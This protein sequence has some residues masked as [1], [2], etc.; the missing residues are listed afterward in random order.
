MKLCQITATFDPNLW[1]SL[2]K[3][4]NTHGQEYRILA[5]DIGMRLTSGELSWSLVYNGEQRRKASIVSFRTV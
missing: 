2:P 3:K 1:E 5:Y 4:T